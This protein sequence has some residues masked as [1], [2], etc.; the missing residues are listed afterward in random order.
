[1]VGDE[2]DLGRLSLEV[3]GQT[4]P[5]YDLDGLVV[6]E[7]L[8]FGRPDLGGVDAEV[9]PPIEA[10]IGAIR[11]A[12]TSAPGPAE[13][14]TLAQL[15]SEPE[16]TG[17]ILPALRPTLADLTGSG[18]ASPIGRRIGSV[19]LCFVRT[20]DD[21]SWRACRVRVLLG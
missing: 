13:Q 3:G 16:T 7:C 14:L 5:A 10:M 8:A 19:E 12:I 2:I 21:R 9:E 20:A 1:M 4:H 6:L 11:I 17:S 18:T 15:P